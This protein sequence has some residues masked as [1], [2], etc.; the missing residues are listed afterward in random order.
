MTGE[1]SVTTNARQ[2]L[3]FINTKCHIHG[4]KSAFSTSQIACK[5]SHFTSYFL[6]SIVSFGVLTSLP[7]TCIFYQHGTGAYLMPRTHPLQFASVSKITQFPC[8]KAQPLTECASI[9]D[10]HLTELW[11]LHSFASESGFSAFCRSASPWF[12]FLL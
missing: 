1:N 12:S 5:C 8:W 4:A 9:L 3:L 7:V 10:D 6:V 2:Y 11:M